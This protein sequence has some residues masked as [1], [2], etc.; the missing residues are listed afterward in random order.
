MS[1]YPAAMSSFMTG[2]CTSFQILY[3]GVCLGNHYQ[4]PRWVIIYS[5]SITSFPDR[6]I[7]K[8][9]I[10]SDPIGKKKFFWKQKRWT[11]ENK[12][13]IRKNKKKGCGSFSR[14]FLFIVLLLS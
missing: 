2:K 12:N 1:Q 13:K 5:A 7:F 6:N 8:E 9:R 10:N 14:C 11:I 3:K 4:T